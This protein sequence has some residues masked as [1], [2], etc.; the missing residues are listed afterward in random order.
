MKDKF[1]TSLYNFFDSDQEGC[2][3]QE[4][5]VPEVRK[6]MRVLAEEQKLKISNFCPSESKVQEKQKQE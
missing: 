4:V 2:I 1:I 5:F 3:T 6:S